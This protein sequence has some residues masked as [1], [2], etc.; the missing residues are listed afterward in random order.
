MIALISFYLM[1]ALYTYAARTPEELSISAGE[2]LAVVDTSEGVWWRVQNTNGEEGLAPANYLESISQ[3]PPPRPP[4]PAPAAAHTTDLCRCI[5]DYTATNTEELR[6]VGKSNLL[7]RLSS[8]FI[9]ISLYFFPFVLSTLFSFTL[10]VIDG[11]LINLLS[12]SLYLSHSLILTHTFSL[13]LSHSHS[14]LS[15]L[16]LFG[17]L[18]MVDTYSLRVGDMITVIKKEAGGWW[19]GTVR[20]ATGWFPSTYVSQEAS[21]P[22]VSIEERD[23]NMYIHVENEI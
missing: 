16:V 13:S 15:V 22:S 5:H 23:M 19:H 20:G 18:A 14:P 10:C 4:P 7:Y 1:Q 17:N 8:T 12:I 3:A 21:P 9:I 2:L 11:S 6:L